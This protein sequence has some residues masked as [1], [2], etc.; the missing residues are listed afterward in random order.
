MGKEKGKYYRD[1]ET[2][3]IDDKTGEVIDS[4]LKR[5][6][7]SYDK[8]PD[9]VKLYL[10][11]IIRLKDLPPSTSKVLYLIVKHM[12]YKNI[13][14]A[15]KPIKKIMCDELDMPITTLNSTII[16]L[17]KAGILIPMAEYGRGLYLV[18]PNLFARGSWNKIK[19]LRLI[20]DYN[21]KTGERQLTSNA[22]EKIKQLGLFEEQ[23]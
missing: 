11:D 10:N 12:G 15:Y 3:V 8:E 4:T 13:F 5:T 17:K 14:Q 7:V 6:Q 1:E 20:V 2:I 23:Q 16:N 18:D 9:Y 21:S 19:D 22:P